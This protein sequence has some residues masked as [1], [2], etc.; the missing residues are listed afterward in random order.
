MKISLKTYKFVAFVIIFSSR[1]TV[2]ASIFASAIFS[3]TFTSAPEASGADVKVAE[4]MADE[5]MDAKTVARD[6]KIIP[7]ATNLYVFK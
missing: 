6:E 1:A 3:A 2:L 4:K 5:K 7:N